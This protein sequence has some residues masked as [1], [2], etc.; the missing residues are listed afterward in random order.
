MSA[1]CTTSD[2]S[3]SAFPTLQSGGCERE[4]SRRAESDRGGRCIIKDS[5]DDQW[6]GEKVI[7][8]HK[9]LQSAAATMKEPATVLVIPAQEIHSLVVRLG[10]LRHSK[11]I[12]EYMLSLNAVEFDLRGFLRTQDLGTLTPLMRERGIRNMCDFKYARP[13]R[14]LFL[15]DSLASNRLEKTPP[16]AIAF[17]QVAPKSD[18]IKGSL[19]VSGYP[20]SKRM[21]TNQKQPQIRPERRS[22]FN[23]ISA[24]A[25]GECR[26]S[27]RIGG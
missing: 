10:L 5:I 20:T 14:S 8:N 27:D 26:G 12:C 3:S 1:R 4:V 21:L 18:L 13:H 6:L 9:L 23:S 17:R 24:Q 25:D 19:K 22:I 7:A 15:A 11:G 2:P 16:R